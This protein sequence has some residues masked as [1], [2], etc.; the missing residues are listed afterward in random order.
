MCGPVS[1]NLNGRSREP[2][3]A[4]AGLRQIERAGADRALD[5][6]RRPRAESH[7]ALRAIGDQFVEG[8]AVRMP[9]IGC[10]KYSIIPLVS[11]WLT[12]KRESSPSQTRSMPACSWVWI[13]TRVAS[14]TACSD[15]SASSQSGTG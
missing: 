4:R 14:I 10:T 8:D 6:R 15:G 7:A 9:A 1:V 11:G 2:L 13:T 12:S 3:R 5:H